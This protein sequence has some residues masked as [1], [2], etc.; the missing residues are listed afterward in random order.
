MP[1]WEFER[2]GEVV[3]VDPAGQLL[4]SIGGASNLSVDAAIAGLGIVYLFEDWLRPYF[5]HGLLVPIVEPW[6]QRFSGPFLYYPGRRLVPAPLRAF[7][8]FIKATASNADA[9]G[10]RP[11]KAGAKPVQRDPPKARARLERGRRGRARSSKAK[12]KAR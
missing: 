6:W 1:P 9:S 4:V 2:D 7:I 10:R 3:K 8:D 11:A 12:G 5:D